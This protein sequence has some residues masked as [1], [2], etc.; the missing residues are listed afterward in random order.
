M[1]IHLCMKY[2]FPSLNIL[3]L[4]FIEEL[5]PL[6]KPT[7]SLSPWDLS[8]ISF[9]FALYRPR[10]PSYLYATQVGRRRNESYRVATK[11]EANE[12][13]EHGPDFIE[14]M[15]NKKRKDSYKKATR[16]D[17]IELDN[18]TNMIRANHTSIPEESPASVDTNITILGHAHAPNSSSVLMSQ[19]GS[20]P[21][22]DDETV[23]STIT[24]VDI[25]VD[26][27]QDTWRY[28]RNLLVITVSFIMVFSAFRAIQNLQSSLNTQG[29]LGVI[30]MACVHGTMF[31]TCLFA[32]VLINKLTSKWTIVL[33]LLFYLFWIVANFYP[34]FYTLIPT[35]IGVGFGQ[36]LA[37]SAQVTYISKLALDYAHLSRQVSEQEAYK[38]NGIFLACF[39]TSHI[40]GNLVSSLVLAKNT[41]HHSIRPTNSTMVHVEEPVYGV[42][43]GGYDT[44]KEEVPEFWNISSTGSLCHYSAYAC[45]IIELS[46][47]SLV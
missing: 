43:C 39:Q 34:H 10:R 7:M 28:R 11:A 44:C 13:D 24:E 17:D 26:L 9:D 2:L 36:S 16:Q 21:P 41:E 42:S 4:F 6:R 30:A 27:T 23:A 46:Q 12:T 3:S 38:F 22:T 18:I 15:V 14:G 47:F 25:G 33:G 40:W 19:S 29:R 8:G 20:A 32:P 45:L 5:G 37:W 1:D 31:L 35:S